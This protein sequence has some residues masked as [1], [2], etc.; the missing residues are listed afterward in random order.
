VGA[1]IGSNIQADRALQIHLAD[2]TQ[3][4]PFIVLPQVQ[5]AANHPVSQVHAQAPVTGGHLDF[6][7]KAAQYRKGDSS[8][9]DFM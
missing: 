5:K 2:Q 8:F 3:R 1:D 6:R 4:F 9:I 7:M